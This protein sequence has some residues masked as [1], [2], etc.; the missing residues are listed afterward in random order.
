MIL[1]LIYQFSLLYHSGL[2]NLRLNVDRDAADIIL[3]PLYR[4]QAQSRH[5]YY[6][7][8]VA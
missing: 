8:F 7:H 2:Q 1:H 5:P 4:S 6:G 3:Y